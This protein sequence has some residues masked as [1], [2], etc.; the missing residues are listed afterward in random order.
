MDGALT[1]LGRVGYQRL[2]KL[3]ELYHVLEDKAIDGS[4]KNLTESIS[5]IRGF[6]DLSLE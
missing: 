5:Q 6:C 2:F 1:G 3:S 4:D